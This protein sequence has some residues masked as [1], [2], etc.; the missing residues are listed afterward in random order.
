MKQEITHMND[1]LMKQRLIKGW[2]LNRSVIQTEP[3]NKPI[4]KQLTQLEAV[5][6]KAARLEAVTSN[7]ARLE[8]V[9]H[10]G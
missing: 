7:A 2:T 1:K 4:T 10:H 6:S 5:K 9:T 8:A 3:T